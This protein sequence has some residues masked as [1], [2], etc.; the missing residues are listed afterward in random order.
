MASSKSP[1]KN[2]DKDYIFNLIMPS[3]PAPA[4]EEPQEA[5]VQ[6]QP[7]EPVEAPARDSL[8]LLQERINQ[9]PSAAVKLRPAKELV[10]VRLMPAGCGGHGSQLPGAKLC[11]CRAGR[12]APAASGMFHQRCFRSTCE[13]YFIC[14]G[15]PQA[16][17]IAPASNLEAGAFAYW[18]WQAKDLSFIIIGPPKH[19]RQFA[20]S[21][22]RCSPSPFLYCV[23][24]Y[25]TFY[26]ISPHSTFLESMLTKE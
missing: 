13:G 10:A 24:H 19:G 22:P 4:D 11:G 21:R 16:L 26:G 8:S 17:N 14:K 23:T 7:L 15:P 1:K 12:R 20:K 25:N 18:G 2:I 5:E 9:A 6:Q 3:G